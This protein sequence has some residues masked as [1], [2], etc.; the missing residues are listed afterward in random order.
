MDPLK[1]TLISKA[2][3]HI[4][5]LMSWLSVLSVSFSSLDTFSS[6]PWRLSKENSRTSFR[7]ELEFLRLK[8]D[9]GSLPRKLSNSDSPWK[10]FHYDLVIFLWC[11]WYNCSNHFDNRCVLLKHLFLSTRLAAYSFFRR[12]ILQSGS[13]GEAKG[14]D[15]RLNFKWGLVS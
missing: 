8:F 13:S 1:K 15:Y 6:N 11:Q 2:K 12:Q 10:R 5:D 7:I 3:F 14:W 9:S 4:Q